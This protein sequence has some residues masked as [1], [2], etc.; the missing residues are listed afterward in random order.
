MAHTP[1]RITLIQTSATTSTRAW[2]RSSNCP[3]RCIVV[4]AFN[5]LRHALR[6]GVTEL[7]QDVE[8][9]ILDASTTAT[10]YLE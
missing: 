2:D 9:V 8:R 3:S 6:S 5:T 1:R 7:G 4:P 10:E